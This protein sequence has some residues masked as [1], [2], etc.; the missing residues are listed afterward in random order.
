M[1]HR[2]WVAVEARHARAAAC[3]RWISILALVACSVVA[4]ARSTSLDGGVANPSPKGR[5][6]T[7]RRLPEAQQ[8][9]DE[10][11]VEAEKLRSIGYLSGYREGPSTSGIV[12]YDKAAA[13][14]GLNL[15]NSG[16]HPGAILMT[17]DGRVLHQ[18]EFPF[19]KA[20]PD[21]VKAAVRDNAQCW[22][23]VHLFPNGDMLAIYE[24][25][26][27]IKIDKD[28]NLIWAYHG[29][30]HHDVKV[31]DDG[32]I[33][34]LTRKAHIVNKVNSAS[35]VLEDFVTILDEN[36]HELRSVS[37]LDAFYGSSYETALVVLG[38]RKGG[39]LFHTNSLYVLD[40]R[41]ADRIPAFKKGNVL[42]SLR[43]LNM[44]AVLDMDSEKIVWG[45]VGQWRRQHD[46]KILPNKDLLVFDNKG[47]GN[48]SKVVEID[49][50]TREVRWRYWGNE[51]APFYTEMCG[52]SHRLPNGDTLIVESDNGRAFEVTRDGRIV[53]EFVNPER[54]GQDGRLIATL[55]DVHR[56]DPATL[57]DWVSE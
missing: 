32:R 30:A 49:P 55:F 25:Y 51:D 6:R 53:W 2:R 15:Y 21:S 22:R 12:V 9:T 42:V 35:P 17:M 11:R 28:S 34:V 41:L 19:L 5:W 13:C 46:A 20:Y 43:L 10:Q 36:G 37:L 52:A 7:A 33:Y 48:L 44:V 45:A 54:A 29:A 27:L 40:G 18:W 31:T 47:H 14:P 50:A 26:G 8:M 39:D 56:V 16:H 38:M 4:F 23:Q 24:G 57:G 3:V 1:E